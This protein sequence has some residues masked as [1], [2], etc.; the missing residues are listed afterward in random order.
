MK[1]EIIEDREQT[2]PVLRLFGGLDISTVG[3]LRERVIALLAEEI[4]ALALD[5]SQVTFADSSGLG[6]LL[7]GK[8]RALE[9]SVGY[10][11]VDC[12]A[13]LQSLIAL[14]GLDQI[15]DFCTWREL[16]E[17]FPAPA[18]RTAASR[19]SGPSKGPEDGPRTL[20]GSPRG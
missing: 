12:P 13:P 20:A 4:P 3:Q 15:M 5:M 18:P 17:R 2:V 7:A 14:V 6:T 9:K 16:V 8:K 1:L 10:Y 11:L 19:P